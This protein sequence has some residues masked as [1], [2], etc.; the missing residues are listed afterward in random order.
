MDK[1]IQVIWQRFPKGGNELLVMLAI[2][3]AS[4][5]YGSACISIEQIALRARCGRSS[6]KRAV[7]AL[8]ESGWLLVGKYTKIGLPA[9]YQLQMEKL[10]EEAIRFGV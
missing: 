9:C 5:A 1:V 10:A 8:K 2:A 3:E 6:V 4:N 7:S